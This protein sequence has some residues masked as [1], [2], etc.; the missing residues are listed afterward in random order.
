[1]SVRG[2]ACFTLGLVSRTLH[3]VQMLEEQG[4][5]TT[6][7]A[8]GR[9]L[10]LCIPRNL[11]LL[12]LKAEF[13]P[14]AGQH[15]SPEDLRRYR[16]AAED[17]DPTSGSILRLVVEMGNSVMYKKVAGELQVLK[18][19]HPGHF[20]DVEVFKKVLIILESHHYRLQ[21]REFILNLFHRSVMRKIV[22]DETEEDTAS[23]T[24]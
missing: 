15:V 17:D 7:D 13:D 12:C 2:T 23:D 14:N 5:E 9:S 4:W 6:L 21:A 18:A 1:M 24:G 19:R 3:G 22:F 8:R 11:Q 20:T 16:K 10:G